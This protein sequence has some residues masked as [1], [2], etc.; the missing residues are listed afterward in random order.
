MKGIKKKYL[1][2]IGIN[3]IAI[4]CVAFF[5]FR[6]Y[7]NVYRECYVEAGVS[8]KPEDFFKVCNEEVYFGNGGETINTYVPGEYPIVLKKGLF[9][10]NS[11]LY[12][13]DTIAPQGQAVNVILGMGEVCEANEFVSDIVDATAVSVEFKEEPDFSRMGK[14][15]V[16]VLLKDLGEN[17]TVVEAEL[18]VAPVISEV[19]VEAG[20]EAPAIDAFVIEGVK[21]EFV[22]DIT[23]CDYSVPAEIPV[24]IK[25]DDNTYDTLMCIV[26]TVA[27]IV[28]VQNV[29]GYLNA[30]YKAD[31]F[32]LSVEDVTE[33]TTKFVKEPD[34]TKEGEQQVTISVIDAGG[35][36]TVK[37]A[38]ITISKDTEAPVIKGVDDIYVVIG[39]SVSY[40]NGVKV[41]DNCPQGLDF[42]VDNSSVNLSVAG[43]Y[44]VT[45]IAKDL[46]GNESS[47]TANVIVKEQKYSED[48][49]NA[50]ADKVLAKIIK[51][52]MTPYEK[53]EAI[54]YYI[55]RNVGYI[56]HSDKG[57]WVQG[58][59]EGLVQKQGDCYVYA[60]TAKVLL[61]RAGITNMDIE[62]IPAKTRHYWNLVDIGEGWY[63]FDT[64]PRKDG[65]IFFMWDEARLMEY[66]VKNKD[67]HNY[68]HSLYPVVN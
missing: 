14:Q 24:T 12:V 27:P 43:T 57:N 63:H 34:T 41:T 39:N 10:H 36:E 11:T 8:V 38:S 2:L 46:A 68:D 61:T 5:L 18:I 3:L 55:R 37:E 50:L 31:D 62:K 66:S 42:K 35:N 26:D 49:V 48:E 51:D 58:A 67:S 60:C 9:T 17:V 44:Q 20:S 54:Y 40:K 19:K 65:T 52:G 47:A 53:V 33:V 64:T 7:S 23:V 32:V 59:Y 25:V 1:L 13:T 30:S 45:Y 16:E 22:T 28:E 6:E 29:V 21:A 15:N 56:S 4:L